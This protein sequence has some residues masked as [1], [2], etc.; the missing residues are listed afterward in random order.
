MKEKSFQFCKML[1]FL[2]FFTFG[3]FSCNHSQKNEN[4]AT[5]NPSQTHPQIEAGLS[6]TKIIVG[7]EVR[8]GEKIVDGELFYVPYNAQDV[9][10][11]T[12]KE[13]KDAK[14]TY[15]PLLQDGKLI[16]SNKETDLKIKL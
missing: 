1:A 12:E 13:P 6:L 7:D 14:I 9:A 15:T 11:V 3:V 5:E 4:K 8:E 16:L 10:I 2:V